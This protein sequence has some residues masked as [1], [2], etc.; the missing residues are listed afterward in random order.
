MHGQLE[1][2]PGIGTVTGVSRLP[3][4]GITEGYGIRIEGRE[5]SSPNIWEESVSAHFYQVVPGYLETLGVPLLAG[6]PLAEEDGPDAPL[7]A[8]I[9]ETMARRYWPDESPIGARFFWNR[10]N[11]ITVVGIVGDIKR[12]ALSADTEPAWFIPFSQLSELYLCFVARTELDP[13][14]V[15]PQMRE[16]VW[17]VDREVAVKN[18]TTMDA[19][20]AESAAD[21]RYRTLLMNVFGIL[22]AMLAAAGV[23]GVTAR[24]VA[25]RTREM[26]IRM[27]LG[28]RE[29]T[30]VG[31]TVRRFLLTG[32]AGTVVGLLAALWLSR[33]IAGFLYGI[34]P[35]DPMTYAIVA[36]VIVTVCLLAS[37]T[38]ARR[39]TKVN[40]VEVLKAE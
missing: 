2:I 36:A 5:Y 24:N 18:A 4:P 19:L 38:P 26:G 16:A 13:R 39:I 11:P 6:R 28:A 29:T 35:S 30:L 10:D 17:T 27:A 34:E 33:L 20:I 3:F 25:L 32:M 21:E 8:V 7:T 23:F 31:T 37:Y 40:P 14:E 12:K 22:A 15:I 1:A 9:N